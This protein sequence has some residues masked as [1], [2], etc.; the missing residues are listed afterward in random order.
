MHFMTRRSS[1]SSTSLFLTLV[2]WTSI[3]FYFSHSHVLVVDCGFQLVFTGRILSP[4]CCLPKWS[5]TDCGN[6]IT[7][8]SSRELSKYCEFDFKSNMFLCCDDYGTD[9]LILTKLT[10]SYNLVCL[11]M[12]G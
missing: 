11:V 1:F 10:N 12:F 2:T 4:L 8:K 3:D 9:C 7:E 6:S 5:R